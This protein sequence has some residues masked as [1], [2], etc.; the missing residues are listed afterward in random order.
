M[1]KLLGVVLFFLLAVPAFADELNIKEDVLEN[2]PPAK[3][4]VAFSLVENNLNYMTVFP[5]YTYQKFTFNVGYA[6]AW[7]PT[8]HKAITM[9]DYELYNPEN[10]NSG[11]KYLDA[12]VNA[13][14]IRPGI[15][16]GAG[17]IE[18]DEPE[19]DWGISLVILQAKFY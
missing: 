14:D 4:G 3:I 11:N 8:G 5:V 2:V 9:V 12:A 13:I 7:E 19:S 10:F 16:G 1:K 6:G 18:K 15:W 17:R